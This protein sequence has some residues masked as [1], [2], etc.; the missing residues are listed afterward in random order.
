LVP[1]RIDVHHGGGVAAY[2]DY[3]PGAPHGV[4]DA[5]A[6]LGRVRVLTGR[7]EIPVVLERTGAWSGNPLLIVR[8]QACSEDACLAPT[9]VELDIALDRA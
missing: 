3:P 2:A 4:A 1:L 8:Y 9:V 7:H 6:G 5:G